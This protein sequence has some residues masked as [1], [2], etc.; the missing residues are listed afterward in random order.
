MDISITHLPNCR[1]KILT[2]R[3]IPVFN[4]FVVDH[5][6]IWHGGSYNGGY[7]ASCNENIQNY[8]PN[9]PSNIFTCNFLIFKLL[10]MFISHPLTYQAMIRSVHLQIVLLKRCQ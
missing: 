5:G 3:E 7:P 10:I 4:R 9:T 1:I 6:L 8:I 2:D